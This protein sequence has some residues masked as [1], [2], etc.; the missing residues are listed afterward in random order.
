MQLKCS[1]WVHFK[2]YTGFPTGAHVAIF[3]LQLYKSMTCWNLRRFIS[4]QCLLCKIFVLIEKIT[5]H[6]TKLTDSLYVASGLCHPVHTT[7][8]VWEPGIQVL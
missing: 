5:S 4:L 1:H 2:Y 8:S 3:N 7:L 6:F